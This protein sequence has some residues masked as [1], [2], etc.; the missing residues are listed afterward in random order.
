MLYDAK[1]TKCNMANAV[2]S[3]PSIPK[4]EEKYAELFAEEL[5]LC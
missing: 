1:Y 4:K 2:A 5:L 3:E